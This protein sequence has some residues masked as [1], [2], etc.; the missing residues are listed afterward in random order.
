MKKI[1]YSLMFVMACIWG[2][3]EDDLPQASWNLHEV[4]NLAAVPLDACVKLSWTAPSE[5]TPSGYFLEWTPSSS[6]Y[7]GGSMTLEAT[8]VEAVVEGLENKISYTF[9]VQ[10]IYGK[11]HSGKVS[12][13]ATPVSSLVPP[14]NLEALAGSEKAKITWTKLS[15]ANVKGY[16]I[17]V[18]PGNKV[19]NVNDASIE[20]Y[21]ISGLQNET[22]YSISLQAVYDKGD[23]EAVTTKVTPGKVDPIVGYKPYV[24]AGSSLTLSYNDMYF[25]GD[26]TSVSWSFGDGTTSTDKSCEKIYATAGEY[27]LKVEVTNADQTK[28]SAE[29]MVIVI[30]TAW[31][32]SMGYVKASNPVF[33][34]DGNTFYLPTANKVG[35]LNA[36][37]TATGEKKWTFAITE[38]IT[39]GGGAAVA[40]DGTIYQGV[41]NGKL[42][43]IH[44]EGNQ[45]WIYDTQATNKNLD[46]F[47]AVTTDGS[48]VY[49][50]DGDNIL[51][52]INTANGNAKWK[53]TLE[54]TPN[55]AGAVAIDRNG[56]I[57]AGTRSYIYAFDATG[58]QL[59]QVAASVTEIGS[60]ALNAGTL[61]AAQTG[62]AGVVAV[63]TQ[64]GQVKWSCAANGDAYA[65]IV[66]KDGT[67]YFVDKGGKS[68]YAV[69]A[70][71]N[72][73]WKFN[74]GAAL[75]YCFPV[76]DDKGMVY[77]GTS[78]GQVFAVDGQSGEEVWHLDAEG[79]GDNA[80]VMAG[81][82][83]GPDEK[84]YIAY[85]GG[86]LK[87][88]SIA[89]GP[90]TTTWSCR[91]GNIHGT[92]QY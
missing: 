61:Y 17:T 92:N 62:G 28:E 83:V 14:T 8:T 59:W 44:A 91:G 78:K 84:L 4:G 68:L 71:G 32:S 40:S 85:I 70:E 88:I 52:A 48:V 18:E 6:A 63:N 38:K 80:K 24:W 73:K 64:D 15:T 50:L 43:A 51:H 21:I 53:K 39:Y 54:G 82:S 25:M 26:V 7:E 79:T 66:G 11:Q 16:K 2:A 13:K 77:F 56:H 74:G 69:S 20:S 58:E 30:G 19:I 86:N 22:E 3:C 10:A 65:P 87:T 75:T 41:R 36:F 33:S 49:I 12:V 42:Y 55:K 35:D 57:Y 81:L 60:F 5:V 90:E 46:C 29:V 89:A 27:T 23:S 76:L 37:N 34:Q 45:K 1:I 31:T 9:T 67:V 72:L 47:P